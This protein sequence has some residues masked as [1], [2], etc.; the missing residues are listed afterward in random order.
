MNTIS[1]KKK[2]DGASFDFEKMKSLYNE[3]ASTSPEMAE[4]RFAVDLY[5]LEIAVE[6]NT[7]Q[8]YG[9]SYNVMGLQGIIYDVMHKNARLHNNLWDPKT[10]SFSKNALEIIENSLDSDLNFRKS[11]IAEHL[12]DEINYGK[13]FLIEL[14]LTAKELVNEEKA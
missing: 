11:G 2:S 4:I 14:L 3:L 13:L 6:R 10:L 9:K 8:S 5:L 1:L 7:R 12:I